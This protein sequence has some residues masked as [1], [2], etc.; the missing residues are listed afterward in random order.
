MGVRVP[1]LAPRYKAE[2]SKKRI[3]LVFLTLILWKTGILGHELKSQS[4]LVIAQR[5]TSG[6]LPE[7][8]LA[9]R[10]P[11]HGLG[12]Y[13]I[14]QD[15]ILTKVNHP[16]VLHDLT[17]DAT[18][19]VNN[20][21]PR[22]NHKNGLFYAIYFTFAELKKLSVRE[23]GNRSGT[24]SKYPQRFSVKSALFKIIT[25]QEEIELIQGMN[26][27]TGRIVGLLIELKD[28]EWHRQEGKDLSAVVMK[29][30]ERYGYKTAKDG[31]Y[32]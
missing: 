1:L 4:P 3:I 24:E 19:N 22:R 9:V 12:A 28:P 13:F 32:V 17:L 6:Y 29:L 21:F 25:L 15:V 30:L 18:T 16:V 20:L 27:S 10:T 14:E 26:K 23:R 11:A 7:H 31:V 5:G 8:T 2:D